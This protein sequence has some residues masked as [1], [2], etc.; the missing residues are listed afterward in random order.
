MSAVPPGARIL[1]LT[2]AMGGGHVQVSRELAR[3]LQTRG[4]EVEVVDLL[5]LMPSAAARFLHWF[6]PWM[7]N[8]APW[9]YDLVYAQFFTAPQAQAERGSVPVRLATP[10]LRQLLAERRPDLVV[11][12]YHLAGV[13]AAR[14]RRSGELD[15]PVVTFI[16]T[17]GV[18]NLWLHPGTDRYLCITGLAA[19]QVRRRG[20]GP[21]DVCEPVV[22][23]NFHEP[24]RK[25]VQQ[26]L[27]RGLSRDERVALI[28]AGSLGMGP[29]EEAA[30]AFA[31]APGWQAVVVCGRN[32]RL[33]ARLAAREEVTALGWVEDM[34]SLTSAAD[35]VVDNAAG[36]TAKEALALGVPVVTYRPIAGHGRD[37][38]QMMHAA[39]VTDVLDD[40]GALVEVATRLTQPSLREQ[41][42]ARGRALFGTDPA[43]LLDQLVTG[44]RS[45]VPA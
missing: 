28:V 38:A 8:R 5:E 36:S 23:P 35:V 14:L 37:D 30:K 26:R 3:R 11:S 33:Q 17:F 2:A 7:V 43:D 41:R 32:A 29:I 6:Y 25:V 27:R 40:P 20:A 4:H 21:V 19:E 44:A 24:A 16:T 42:A 31:R 9:L 12:T 18:H 1:V 22:R 45:S 10:G 39:G 13:A 34:A 15:A